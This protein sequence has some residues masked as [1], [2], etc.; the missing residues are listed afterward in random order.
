MFLN[1]LS[2]NF[3]CCASLYLLPPTCA[4]I[5]SINNDRVVPLKQIK[6]MPDNYAVSIVN[7]LHKY[8][9]GLM[10]KAALLNAINDAENLAYSQWT[11]YLK[12]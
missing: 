12:T 1:Q 5:Q 11:A 2:V 10:S 8:N 3:T 9:A 7:N 4:G 6:V